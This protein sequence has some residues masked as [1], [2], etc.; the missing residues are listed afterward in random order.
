VLRVVL[1]DDHDLFRSMLRGLLDDHDAIEVV[2]E[3][4]N[5]A[6]ALDVVER[7]RPD[8]VLMDVRMPVMNGI[9]A[10]SAIKARFPGIGVLALSTTGELTAVVGMAKSGA[11]GYVLKGGTLDDLI[12]AI[13]DAAA[14]KRMWPRPERFS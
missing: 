6:E 12:A 2:G 1:V 14:G 13:E 3:A 4:G 9:E 11:S 7:T 5:G 10:T 8:V